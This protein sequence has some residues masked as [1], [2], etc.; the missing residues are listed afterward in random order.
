MHYTCPECHT[1]NRLPES[2]FA[3]GNCGRCQKSLFTGQPVE[4]TDANFQ[5]FIAKNDMPI[6]VDFW[7]AWCGPCQMMAPVFS[8]LAG[9]LQERLRFAKVNTEVAQQTSAQLGIR[10]IPTLIV[11]HQGKEIDRLAGA[12]PAAQLEQW[13]NS[14]LSKI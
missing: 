5:R 9:K 14:A 1:I 8:E 3:Q 10:S 13:L 11:Y 12:L 2:N 4:L 7:A 6:V